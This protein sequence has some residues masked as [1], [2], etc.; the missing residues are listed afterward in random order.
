MIKCYFTLFIFLCWD[1]KLP[2]FQENFTPH[3]LSNSFL[4][5]SQSFFSNSIYFHPDSTDILW[6]FPTWVCLTQKIFKE[7]TQLFFAPS[8]PASQHDGQLTSFLSTIIDMIRP[9]TSLSQT[10]TQYLT[11]KIPQTSVTQAEKLKSLLF[12]RHGCWGSHPQPE[13]RWRR[14]VL[15]VLRDLND[16]HSPV[17]WKMFG[18]HLL[19]L[20]HLL[21]SDL[22][23]SLMVSLVLLDESWS[24]PFIHMVSR[25]KHE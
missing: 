22:L 2:L 23:W 9:R 6:F 5:Y 16:L 21:L 20:V 7:T 1:R 25:R 10:R 12:V 3:P 4:F 15:F 8:V 13:R 19:H 18:Q 17:L 11:I 24:F 14:S